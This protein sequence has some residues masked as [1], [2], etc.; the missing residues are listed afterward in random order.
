MKPTRLFGLSLLCCAIAA[1]ALADVT[2][3]SKGSG[4]GMIGAICN[5]R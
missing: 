2:L 3:K 5:R 4:T 1:P